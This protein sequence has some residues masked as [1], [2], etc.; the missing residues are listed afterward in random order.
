L[1]QFDWHL[2]NFGRLAT[3]LRGATD[4]VVVSF[5]QFYQNLAETLMPLPGAKALSGPIQIPANKKRLQND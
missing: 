5:A 4:E 3:A 1:T 2:A